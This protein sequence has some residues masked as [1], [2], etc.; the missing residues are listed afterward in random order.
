MQIVQKLAGYSLGRA[1][2]VR[3]GMAKKKRN[4]L[5]AEKLVFIHGNKE[6]YESGKDKN[7]APGCVANGIPE[8]IAEE[9]WAQMDKF[10]SYAFNRSHAACYAWLA[11]I[12]A[13]MS[14][15]W[16]AEFYCAMIDVYKRQAL[17]LGLN[18]Y[19]ITNQNHTTPKMH[20]PSLCQIPVPAAS[21]DHTAGKA[22]SYTH[23]DVYKRQGLRW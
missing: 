4:I 21:Q 17:Y 8:A 18:C 1:D 12:T 10:A 5:D 9:I 3:K 13:Y 16:T 7:Y 6:A 19:H 23:L 15:H 22:V 11:S 14:C 20:K 2:V